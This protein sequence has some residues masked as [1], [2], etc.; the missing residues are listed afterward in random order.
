[1]ALARGS[2]TL[3]EPTGLCLHLAATQDDAKMEPIA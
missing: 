3:G 1:M 2:K